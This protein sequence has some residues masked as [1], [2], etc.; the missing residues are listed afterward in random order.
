MVFVFDPT[1][2]RTHDPLFSITITPPM[3]YY[4]S[5]A[6]GALYVTFY[7]HHQGRIQDVWLGGGGRE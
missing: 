3:R 4:V 5:N 1:G 7:D 2:A 6:F